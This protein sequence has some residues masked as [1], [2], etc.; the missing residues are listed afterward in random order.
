MRDDILLLNEKT[1]AEALR[2]RELAEA[3]QERGMYAS[4]SIS[5]SHL[6][7]SR[8]YP[9]SFSP[10]PTTVSRSELNKLMNGWLMQA[11]IIPDDDDI[12]RRLALVLTHA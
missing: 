3:L 7:Y 12:S 1:K 11:V 5:L 4:L 9:A 8:L 10:N 6:S 2:D